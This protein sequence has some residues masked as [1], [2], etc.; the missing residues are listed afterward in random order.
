MA[1]G[2]KNRS[3]YRFIN[4]VIYVFAVIGVIS[5]AGALIKGIDV[6]ISVKKVI[7]EAPEVTEEYLTPNEYSRP[8]TPLTE[9]RGLVIHYV[10]NGGT[11]AENNRNYFEGLKDSKATY[12]SS[13]YIID[14]DGEII[15]CIP[16]S[17]IS[18]ASNERNS[19]TIAIECC[20]PDDTGRFTTD[21]YD[22]LVYLTA[23]L[24]GEYDLEIDDV[25]RHYDISGKDC[26]KYFVDNPEKWDEF[27][28]DVEKYIDANGEKVWFDKE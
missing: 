10:A 23:W 28:E 13:H 26:P 27:K 2:R 6:L 24:M 21:T 15:Q 4:I 5:T 20:H 11:S 9:V 12:A 1:S 22:T 18:Y 25:I 19:D 3:R 14:L 7:K 16:L 17:E 8:G